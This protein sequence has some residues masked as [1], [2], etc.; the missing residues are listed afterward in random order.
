MTTATIGITS[1]PEVLTELGVELTRSGGAEIVGRCPV[2]VKRVG[3]ADN[4]PSWSM[5]SETGLWIC[6]S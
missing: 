5:K 2:H 1:L 4:S 6:C 3:K